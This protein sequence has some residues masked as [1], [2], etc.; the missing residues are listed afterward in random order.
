MDNNTIK[1]RTL[2]FATKAAFDQA[3]GAGKITYQHIA[4]ISDL[5]KIWTHGGFYPDDTD[6]SDMT[7]EQIAQLQ[8]DIVS[9]NSY[10]A[11]LDAYYR[12]QIDIINNQRN[13]NWE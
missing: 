3:L 1:Q 10:I 2:Y 9:V 5:K 12:N 13:L 7:E 11:E 6:T 8:K 4:F